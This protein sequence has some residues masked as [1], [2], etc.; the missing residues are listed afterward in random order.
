MTLTIKELEAM[1]PLDQAKTLQI[2]LMDKL[3]KDF[4]EGKGAEEM[5][6]TLYATAAVIAQILRSMTPLDRAKFYA[7]RAE[8]MVE[9]LENASDE[10]R[11]WWV[12]YCERQ[13]RSNR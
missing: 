6:R 3:D 12:D 7:W 5:A 2:E 9:I 13:G 1:S 11:D 10:T 8:M 4:D